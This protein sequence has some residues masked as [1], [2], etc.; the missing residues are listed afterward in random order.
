MIAGG[1]SPNSLG[2]DAWKL[3]PGGSRVCARGRGQAHA[4]TSGT[5]TVDISA[6]MNSLYLELLAHTAASWSA[7]ETAQP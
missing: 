7:G 3:S 4:V 2:S 1:K 6:S 5:R